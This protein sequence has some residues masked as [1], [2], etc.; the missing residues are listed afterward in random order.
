ML[1][2]RAADGGIWLGKR[3]RGGCHGEI[4]VQHRIK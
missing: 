1:L 2:V 4:V 3:R